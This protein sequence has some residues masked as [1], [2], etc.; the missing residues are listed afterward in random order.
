[1]VA[2]SM[3]FGR[4]RELVAYGNTGITGRAMLALAESEWVRGLTLLDLHATSVTDDGV[5]VYL[6]S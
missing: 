6:A 4:L 1:M 5:A 2:R 3:V